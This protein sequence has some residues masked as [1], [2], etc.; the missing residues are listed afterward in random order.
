[1]LIAA[2]EDVEKMSVQL[3]QKRKDVQESVKN[4]DQL[5]VELNAKN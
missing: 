4:C 5:L 3:E 2:K 1:M